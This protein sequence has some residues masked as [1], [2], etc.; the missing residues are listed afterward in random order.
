MPNISREMPRVFPTPTA[1]WSGACLAQRSLA[2]APLG[3]YNR[4]S[5]GGRNHDKLSECGL[6]LGANLHRPS[7]S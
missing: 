6:C 7:P 3:R 1:L 4:E 2:E 5:V